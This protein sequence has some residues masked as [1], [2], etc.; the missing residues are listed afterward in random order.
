M[1]IHWPESTSHLDLGF[2]FL[3]VMLY[4]IDITNDFSGVSLEHEFEIDPTK[5]E[6]LDAIKSQGHEFDPANEKLDYYPSK[7][8]FDGGFVTTGYLYTEAQLIDF[9]NYVLSKER[10]SILR[11]PDNVARA[12]T[13]AY[14]GVWKTRNQFGRDVDGVSHKDGSLS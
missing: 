11:N 14:L 12:V 4:T 9:T 1:E 6:V 7:T 2:I 13:D 5:Q 8:S 3:S 10:E